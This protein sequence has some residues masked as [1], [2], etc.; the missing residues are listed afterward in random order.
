MI[1]DLHICGRNEV[2]RRIRNAEAKGD[3][4][5]AVISLE[6]PGREL[7]RAS[8]RLTE[9]LGEAWKGRQLILRC[10]DTEPPF[11]CPPEP[12]PG[13]EIIEEALAFVKQFYEQKTRLKLLVHCSGGVSR[14]P[15]L[16][17]VLLCYVNGPGNEYDC[18]CKVWPLSPAATYNRAIIVHGDQ[19]LGCQGRLSRILQYPDVISNRR[20]RVAFGL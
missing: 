17:L 16:G 3:P 14:S 10:F 8:P 19:I 2:L 4:F 20:M 1:L 5:D 9:V 11:A 18:L 6:D 13:P 15:A 7:S 12:A